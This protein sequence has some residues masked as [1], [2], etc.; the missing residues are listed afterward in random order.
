MRKHAFILSSSFA[1]LLPC[2]DACAQ[3]APLPTSRD[4]PVK[5]TLP[6]A[7]SLSGSFTP[8]LVGP[9]PY[10]L[11]LTHRLGLGDKTPTHYRLSVGAT[12]D[13]RAWQ[14]YVP[15]PIVALGSARGSGACEQRPSAV[16]V[17][18]RMQ[19]GHQTVLNPTTKLP[20]VL[21][22]GKPL[23]GFVCL[24]VGG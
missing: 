21:E 9:A 11:R 24:F 4:V 5:S 3:T 2:A 20:V 15:E 16:K 18:V 10:R 6:A 12:M 7:P 22:S 14:P 23:E 13:W 1:L 17:L 19:L 8:S